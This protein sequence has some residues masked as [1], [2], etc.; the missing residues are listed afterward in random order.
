MVVIKAIFGSVCEAA[1]TTLVVNKGFVPPLDNPLDVIGVIEDEEKFGNLDDED[2]IHLCLILAL[3][4]IFM[5]RNV[6][7]KHSDEHYFGLK[8]DRMYVP[9]YT[10]SGFV[11]AFQVWIFESFERCN[12]W[13]IKDPKV[14]PRALEW[15]KKSIFQKSD[16]RY[17]FAKESRTT[18]DI[19]PTLA[20]YDSSWWIRSQVY[21]REHVPKAPVI[22]HHS[23]FETYL[24]KLEKSRKRAHASCRVS[25]SFCTT[26]ISTNKKWLKDEVISD[27]NVRVFKLETI[28]HV[29]ARERNE[30]NGVLHFNE[31]FSSLGRDFIDSLNI[32][33]NDLIKPHDSDEDISNEKNSIEEQRFRMEEANRMRLE[34]D[35]MLQ[36]AEV[37]KQ[38]RHEFMN[39]THVKTIL[40]KLTPS[41]GNH[42]DYVTGKT[43][44]KQLKCKFPWREDYTVVRH[45][46]LAL[47]CLDPSQKGWLSEEHI[48]L[49]VDYM[50]HGRPENANWA[51]YATPWSDVDQVYFPINETAQHWCLAQ[52]DILSRLVTFY[53][54]GYTYDY[55]WRDYN[56]HGETNV[57]TSLDTTTYTSALPIGFQLSS[58]P[59]HLFATNCI[60]NMM[61]KLFEVDNERDFRIVR[62]TYAMCHELNVRCEDRREQMIEMQSFLHVLVESYNLLKEL[63][64]YELEKCMELMKSICE[65]Q[66]KER[67]P[68]ILECAKVFDKK[69]IN[70]SDYC[71]RFKLAEN[72]PKQGGIFG[73]CGVWV[74]IFL[75][76]L[77]H[78]LSL[79]VE[80]PVN[81]ALA[82]REKMV[83]FPTHNNTSGTSRVVVVRALD[84]LAVVS[85]ETKLPN[86]MRF[87]FLQQVAEA[88]AFAKLI[89]EKAD[90]ARACLAKLV[91]MIG[92]LEA[93]DE[94]LMG[95][96]ILDCLKQSKELENITLKALSDL[97]A[98]A[99]EAIHLKEGHV[100][101][102]DLEIDH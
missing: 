15:L 82:Y 84:E 65:T 28:I 52:L 3:E 48:D 71:I 42:V 27:L 8:K 46:W 78:G 31:E 18:T 86:Y 41:K 5:G 33:F 102:M 58:V 66:L 57:Y 26:D 72:V 10:L 70:Q 22:Q 96:D 93:M 44:P 32:L 100:D 55:E 16:C 98:H 30:E 35:K 61:V 59:L 80:D 94:S 67:L 97:I 62:E 83:R 11:F 38:K 6:I 54:S 12:G 21:F 51:M 7:Q 37:K 92:E 101:F 50:W 76:R 23:L 13:W 49:W 53:D 1:S 9:T 34:E 74:C 40:A 75:Y 87:F 25:S 90:N 47:S 99:E 85:N 91:V 17:L 63:Q 39:S 95:F 45:F 20:E 81:V 2:S 60:L 24:S 77:S 79:D 73:D 68:I 89:R 69:G 19:K 88:K 29:L 14:I 56:T 43:N 4:V 64:D 36:I